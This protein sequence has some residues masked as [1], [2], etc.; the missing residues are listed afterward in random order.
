MTKELLQL[1][2][3]FQV[4]VSLPQRL[5]RLAFAEAETAE[6]P[7]SSRVDQHTGRGDSPAVGRAVSVSK[8]EPSS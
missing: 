2:I 8:T 6:R 5:P 1:D 7:E 3:G 4:G